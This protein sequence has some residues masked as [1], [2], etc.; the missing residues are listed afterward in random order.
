[1]SIPRNMLVYH[2]VRL[3]RGRSATLRGIFRSGYRQRR[4]SVAIRP[5]SCSGRH[6][7][8]PAKAIVATLAGLVALAAM[9]AGQ[10]VAAHQSGA[11]TATSQ[12]VAAHQSGAT[13]ATSQVLG[14]YTSA[15]NPAGAR[16]FGSWLGHPVD[17]AM[18][19][20][21][22]SSWQ[23][24]SSPSWFLEHWGCKSGSTGCDG[25]QMI[26]GVPMLPNSG[27]SL[28]IGA[29]GA[30]D[31]YFR[32]LA[33]TLVAY[34]QGSSFIRLGWEF[35]GWWF[36][37]AVA[38]QA[39]ATSFI[40]YWRQIVVTMQSVAGANFKFVWNPTRGQLTIPPDEAY[41]GNA[42]VDVV[43]LDVY[44]LQW[45]AM[46][47]AARWNYMLTEP[48]GL[49][50]LRSFGAAHGKALALPEWGLWPTGNGHGGGDD[51]YF[52]SEM[53]SW[54]ASNNVAFAT[55]FDHGSNAINAASFPKAAAQFLAS[56]GTPASSQG[57][58]G[59]RTGGTLTGTTITTAPASP[60]PSPVPAPSGPTGSAGG[61]GPACVVA[62]PPQNGEWDLN[63]SAT[64]TGNGVRLTGTGPFEAGSAIWPHPLSSEG[65]SVSFTATLG[66]GTGANGL[67]LELL[68]PV[69]GAHALGENGG[70]EGF[71]GLKGE[72]VA[73]TT[74]TTGPTNLVGMADRQG[75][76]WSTLHY[77]VSTS[78]VPELRGSPVQV[79]VKVAGGRMSVF[80]NGAQAFV[81]P[82]T[83]SLPRQV[84]VGF[85]AASGYF[86]DAHAVSGVTVASC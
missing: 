81:V 65:L 59:A 55:Y 32:K 62:P 80:V 73:L 67:V 18:D 66:G 56:F 34:G 4:A 44:D 22:G 9:P 43:G 46:P 82:L 33:E 11:T 14:V 16:A 6:W 31:I 68:D 13:T 15:A 41:P 35:N 50:W 7:L 21:D 53:A 58:G 60:A 83:A 28:S 23:T 27:A 77:V 52:V 85:A 51:P 39:E 74:Y 38:N 57:Q 37:W 76:T 30:Y 47:N 49:D 45:P 1:M 64:P 63:G 8:S 84:L 86:T 25:F 40:S 29:T 2:V 69:V 19:F 79:N 24:I 3:L 36:P 12:L 78:Q 75:S 71:A 42:Y 70:G 17:Y 10:L 26:W 48:Y 72:A 61:T 54:I 20:F 5:I